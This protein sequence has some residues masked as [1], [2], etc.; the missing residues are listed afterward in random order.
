MLINAYCS[1]EV[2]WRHSSSVIALKHWSRVFDTILNHENIRSGRKGM[3]TPD[4][5]IWVQDLYLS[6]CHDLHFI[7]LV[8]ALSGLSSKA[9]SALESTVT[10]LDDSVFS[11]MRSA[12][13]FVICMKF[14]N[15]YART[16]YPIMT[17]IAQSP[18]IFSKAD[19]AE[20]AGA[21]V[22]GV[23]VFVYI[24]WWVLLIINWTD[25]MGI[26]YYIASHP[27]SCHFLAQPVN[28]NRIIKWCG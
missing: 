20:C 6:I 24:W 18:P 26:A 27:F 21:T 2:S 4:R 3:L 22:V 23:F 14:L 11:L 19:F 28:H 9:V 16:L 1:W 8:Q 17:E 13:S 5:E 15:N 25:V 12:T 10:T 7:G